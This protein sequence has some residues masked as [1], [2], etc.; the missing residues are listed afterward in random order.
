MK[1][2]IKKVYKGLAEVRDYDVDSCINLNKHLEIVYFD[3]S[4]ILSPEELK[5]KIKSIS[6]VFNS[7]TGGKNYKLYGYKWEPNEEL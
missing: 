3:E 2:E 7:K 4:M 5:T 1:I 6:K